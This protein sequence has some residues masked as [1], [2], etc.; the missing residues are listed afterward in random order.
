MTAVLRRLGRG[1]HRIGRALLRSG[2]TWQGWVSAVVVV[3]ATVAVVTTWGTGKPAPPDLPATPT[4]RVGVSDG[5]PVPAY[6][7]AQRAELERLTTQDPGTQVYALVSF[8]RYLTPAQVATVS[9]GVTTIAGYARAPLP[10][11]QTELVRLPANRLPDDLTV[12]ITEVAGRKTAEAAGYRTQTAKGGADQT[13]YGFSADVASREADSY[14][15]GAGCVYALVVRATPPELTALADRPDVRVVDAAPEVT[16]VAQGVF[17]A[18]LP[19]QVDRVQPLPDG[20][21]TAGH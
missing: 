11:Q 9:A 1:A 10:G 13:R 7:A 8:T 20:F 21:P 4:G 15:S 19:E 5:D 16:D 14:R 18:P 2:R 17:V 6:V 12:A 3:A